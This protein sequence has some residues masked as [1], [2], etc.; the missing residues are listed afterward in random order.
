M[1]FSVTDQPVFALASFWQVSMDG[2][3]FAMV[4]CD[5]NE[6]VAPTLPM[7][8]ITMLA[9]EDHDTWPVGNS[10]DLRAP[11]RPY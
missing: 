3:A 4:T 8:M 7:A 1:W 6:L 10:E 9:P 2:G 5:A 11:Q